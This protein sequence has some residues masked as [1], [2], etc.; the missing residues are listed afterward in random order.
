VNR[1][2]L[3]CLLLLGPV[4][5]QPPPPE[6]EE[7]LPPRL[8]PGIT[9]RTRIAIDRGLAHLVATQARDG[10]WRSQGGFGT[11]PTTMTALAGLSLL[12]G[13]S[14]PTRG[15]HA[16][17]LRRALTFLLKSARPDGLITRPEDGRS[18]YG[19]GFAMLFL[20]Q[21]YGVEEDA[22]RALQIHQVLQRAVRLTARSQSA[23][24]GWLYTPEQSGDEGSVTVTQ[25][26]ALRG[27]RNAGVKV[28]R[29][30]IDR[31][32]AYIANSAQPDGGIAYRAGMTG[33]RPAI[34]AAAVATLYNAGE[35]DHPIARK[36]LRYALQ[37]VRVEGSSVQGH[38][39][40]AH[41]YMAQALWQVGGNEWNEYFRKMRNKLLA[42]QA[43]NGS[44]QG[45][46]VGVIY[47]TAIATLI[48]QLPY[49][50]LPILMR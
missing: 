39:F 16:E 18:M 24:G 19:H 12:A 41:L 49:Q 40:Y 7:T 22:A 9:P 17:S 46:G 35:Y 32:V 38:Y 8:P 43:Q 1:S 30:T 23:L 36:A 37:H 33:S 47:G 31:A 10:S 26:Q 44:W 50:H 34:T 6:V 2:I 13:G 15:P 48:L 5:A 28:P 20:S 21:V 11:Y 42:T 45:D 3:L 29:R 14:T 25:I 27:C 4:Q